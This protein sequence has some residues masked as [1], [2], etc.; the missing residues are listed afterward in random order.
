MIQIKSEKLQLIAASSG[1]TGWAQQL[2]EQH[3]FNNPHFFE[4]VV[5]HFGIADSMGTN[6]PNP[7]QFAAWEYKLA[8]HEETARFREQAQFQQQAGAAVAAPSPYAQEQL[9]RAMMRPS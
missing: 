7:P 5:E 4:S 9:D 2:K 3:D 8:I 1:T 6:L